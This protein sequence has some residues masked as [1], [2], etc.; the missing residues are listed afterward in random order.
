MAPANGSSLKGKPYR[1]KALARADDA[2]TLRY[3]KL[4]AVDASSGLSRRAGPETRAFERPSN[5]G[6]GV[7]LDIPRRTTPRLRRADLSEETRRVSRGRD[8]G[9]P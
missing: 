9:I 6:A 1:S 4:V 2:Y 8:D 7:F 3:E 5:A